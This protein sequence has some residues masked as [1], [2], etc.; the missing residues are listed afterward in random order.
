LEKNPAGTPRCTPANPIKLGSEA[1]T[2][3]HPMQI[4]RPSRGTARNL[5]TSAALA[6]AALLLAP[7]PQAHAQNYPAQNYPPQTQ[8]YPPQAQDYPPQAQD[9]PPQAQ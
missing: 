9:Y 5:L 4:Q 3:R 6:G 2:G 8:D 7:A 1:T